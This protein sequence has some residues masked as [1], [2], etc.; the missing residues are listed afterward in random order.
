MAKFNI[1]SETKLTNASMRDH[2]A[3]SFYMAVAAYITEHSRTGDPEQSLQDWLAAGDYQDV[4]T[5]ASVI[6]EWD[7]DRE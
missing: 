4:P 2:S 3:D 5:V 1:T 6:A 7:S